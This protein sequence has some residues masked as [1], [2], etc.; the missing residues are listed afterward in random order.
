MYNFDADI[1]A[2]GSFVDLLMALRNLYSPLIRVSLWYRSFL[3]TKRNSL[4]MAT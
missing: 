2:I 1:G 4:A 3:S